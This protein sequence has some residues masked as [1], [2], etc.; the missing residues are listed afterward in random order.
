MAQQR[1]GEGAVGGICGIR[2][3]ERIPVNKSKGP[4]VS[5]NTSRGGQWTGTTEAQ[6]TAAVE[7]IPRKSGS[8]TESGPS[9]DQP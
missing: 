4:T 2:Y 5:G 9:R 7:Q 6:S 8:A 1:Q 3:R